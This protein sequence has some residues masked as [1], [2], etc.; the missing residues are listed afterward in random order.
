MGRLAAYALVMISVLAL[1]CEG[2]RS[3]AVSLARVVPPG[4]ETC[5]A[6]ADARTLIVTALGDHPPS[7][8]TAFAPDL[9]AGGSLRVPASTRVVAVELLGAGGS[10][11]AVGRTAPFVADALEGG[12]ALPV[13]MAPPRGFCPVG[14]LAEPRIR[15]LAAPAAGGVLVAG[16]RD[17]AAGVEWY[18]PA[19]GRFEELDAALYAGSEA[20]L[21]GATMTSL[22]DGRVVVAGGAQPAYQIFD[23]DAMAFGSALLMGETRARHAA[24]ALGDGRLL[25]AGGCQELGPQGECDE[26]GLHTSTVILDVDR[27]ELS[28]GPALAAPRLDGIALKESRDAVLLVGGY[29]A[30]GE[31]IAGGERLDLSARASEDVDDLAAVA[32]APLASGSVLAIAAD[33]AL[34]ML[35]P[36]ASAAAPAGEGAARQGGTATALDDGRILVL[37]GGEAGLLAPG[38]GRVADLADAPGAELAVA[39]TD[40]AA[41]KLPDG[42]VLVFGGQ[43]AGGEALADAHLFRPDLT[44]PYTSGVAIAFGERDLAEQ[45]VPR[46][47]SRADFLAASGDVPAHLRLESAG[48]VDAGAPT[49]WGIVGGPRFAAP[50]LEARVG[51]D[52]GVAVLVGF[53]DPEARWDVRLREGEPAELWQIEAGEALRERDCSPAP[54][55][56]GALGSIASPALVS[57]EVGAAGLVVR[58]GGDDVLICPDLRATPFGHVGV[59]PLGDDGAALRIDSLLVER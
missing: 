56:E 31:P 24:V 4:A 51:T 49:Q 23:P 55:P 44:G 15:P 18:D 30:D 19:R 7:G 33:G 9:A 20:G 32:A 59:A 57:I 34:A 25:L 42:S 36:G 35:S 6:P 54:V 14:E 47:T 28:P 43:G 52:D 21:E 8:G 2:E 16:G 50:K 29:D 39:R 48:E 58:A 1:A 12:A 5:G 26:D 3:V 41:V 22:A 11:R 37:G 13:A 27:G 38:T 46:D 40:H 17:A 53:R 45:V 10:L